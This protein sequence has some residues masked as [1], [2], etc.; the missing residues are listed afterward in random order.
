M[1]TAPYL[2]VLVPSAFAFTY[3][4][5]HEG[6]LHCLSKVLTSLHA[7]LG[8]QHLLSSSSGHLGIEETFR[9]FRVGYDGYT[10][11]PGD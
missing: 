2:R 5:Q 10:A 11:Q 4:Q 9:A 8:T 1:E 7:S 6:L 3:L